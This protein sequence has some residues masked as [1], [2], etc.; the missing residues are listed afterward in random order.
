MNVGV[1]NLSS[2][3]GKSYLEAFKE[4][5]INVTTLN[6]ESFE[7]EITGFDGVV[8]CENSA[9][10]TARTC[11]ILL[12]LKERAN[13]HIWVFSSNLP[14]IMRTVYLQLGVLGIISEEC[15]PEELQLIISNYLLRSDKSSYCI[16]DQFGTVDLDGFGDENIQL[17]PRNHSVKI[18]NQEEIPLT[19]LEYKAMELLYEHVNNTVLYK[20]LF[21]A[22]WGEGFDIQNNYRVANLIFHL[23]EKI[24][25]NSVSPLLIRTVRSQG[26][27]L[28][29]KK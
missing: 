11:S 25:D 10:D 28:S 21:E 22:I 17:I 15:E 4:N 19:R 18:N 13:T 5:D 2:E 20:E 26:Y 29:L 3:F 27:M 23:R 9:K 6:L 7:K 14:K 8:I 1:V 16:G 24:E 12:K